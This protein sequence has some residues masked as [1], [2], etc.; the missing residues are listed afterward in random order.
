VPPYACFTPL[1]RLITDL[2]P[3]ALA[4][5][6]NDA[7]QVFSSLQLAPPPR[8][9]YSIAVSSSYEAVVFALEEAG[10]FELVGADGVVLWV[11][12][13]AFGVEKLV[14]AEEW[15]RFITDA[16]PANVQTIFAPPVVLPSA[17][18]LSKLCLLPNNRF[19]TFTQDLSAYSHHL[20]LP[21]A[22]RRWF[23][24]RP[25]WRDGQLWYPRQVTMPMGW[26]AAVSLAQAAHVH[27]LSVRAP[28]VR[29]AFALYG[30]LVPTLVEERER[31][32]ST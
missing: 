5:V 8:P 24:F 27:T 22:L 19:A 20:V 23:G 9:F 29:S 28:L 31:A 25:V 4:E 30:K 21:P 32:G 3:D 13:G 12:N 1:R 10:V 7:S 6:L 18:H 15:A 14:S 11:V 2:L 16:R 26:S 17:E